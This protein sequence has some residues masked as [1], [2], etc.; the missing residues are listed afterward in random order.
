[1]ELKMYDDKA[2]VTLEPS[3][4]KDV[5]KKISDL[6]HLLSFLNQNVEDDALDNKV[7]HTTMGLY[8]SY[9]RDLA[10][11]LGY[12][13]ILEKEHEDR[14]EKIRQKNKEIMELESKL[15]KEVSPQA[16]SGAI[17]FYE[18]IIRAWYENEGFHYA[19]IT[20]NSYG[21]NVEL[22]DEMDY[23]QDD[24][25]KESRNEISSH[26]WNKNK[27]T[28][29]KKESGWDIDEDKYHASILDTDNNRSR[30]QK[31]ILS[32]FPNT[33]INGFQS[34]HNDNHLFALTTKCFIS[35]GNVVDYYETQK[36]QKSY[37][38]HEFTEEELSLLQSGEIV[39]II[40]C[41]ARVNNSFDVKVKLD[42]ETGKL[43][44]RFG[45]MEFAENKNENEK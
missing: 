3:I 27:N 30:I 44:I 10:K 33:R 32:D 39:E 2:P 9:Y 19:S 25:R 21:L 15:G 16:V 35:Y 31:L 1:M 8:E 36:I 13:T 42:K 38:G 22:S 29:E 45:D 24:N 18:D 4:K 26:V 5:S 17:K 12:D 40:G 23:N 43:M 34:R 28:I 6:Y 20:V 14:F 11:M 37:C 41:K 7:V